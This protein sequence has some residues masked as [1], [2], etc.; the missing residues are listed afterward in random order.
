MK[1]LLYLALIIVSVLTSCRK[2]VYSTY[3]KEID[4]DTMKVSMWTEEGYPCYQ[5]KV[6]EKDSVV[7]GDIVKYL[8]CPEKILYCPIKKCYY[9][10]VPAP[11]EIAVYDFDPTYNYH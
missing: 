7:I 1:K 11:H 3:Y 10:L 2:H 6:I 5:V 8:D 9:K 4:T